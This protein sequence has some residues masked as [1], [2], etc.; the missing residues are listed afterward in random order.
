[1]FRLVYQVLSSMHLT[2][3]LI[4]FSI[5]L[6]F[7][8]TLDQ[9][10][11]GIHEAQKKYFESFFVIWKYPTTW[12]ASVIL[13]WL[14]IPLPGGFALGGALVLNLTISHFRYFK[15]SWKNFGIS[16]T[17]FGVLLLLISGF[18]VSFYQRESIMSIEKGKAKNYSESF[19]NHEIVLIDKSDQETDRVYSVASDSLKTGNL[20]KDP[21]LPLWIEIKE[22]YSHAVFGSREKN[23][24]ARIVQANK[25]LGAQGKLVFFP[26]APSY[27]EDHIN[28]PTAIVTLWDNERNLGTWLISSFLDQG[29]PPQKFT[30][31]DKTYEITLRSQR[32]YES[33]SIYLDEVAHDKYPGT[34]IA[35]NFSSN[36]R[37]ENND[38]GTD[39]NAL[40]YMNH[41]LRYQGL[42]Y[43]QYQ[44]IAEQGITRFQVVKNPSWLLPYVSVALVG[45]GLV[46]QFSSHLF[47]FGRR[48]KVS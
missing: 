6:V 28:W 35:K 39:R 23:P 41:P 14:S 43:Y 4:S 12:P 47:R 19:Y 45:I 3:I 11:I 8:G 40:V 10:H 33:Y 48:Q 44:M 32:F 20:I 21:S 30:H 16:V 26:K 2:V 17:H 9:V 22:Y 25:G 36:I 29:F 42:T 15:S 7:L 31:L 18:A 13:F 1:M 46:V 37:I 38:F 27:S 34:E 5:L 24:Q